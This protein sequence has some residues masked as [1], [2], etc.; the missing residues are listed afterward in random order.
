[1]YSFIVSPPIFKLIKVGRHVSHPPAG[2]RH[3][4]H[5]SRGQP[6]LEANH[7]RQDFTE[8]AE[9]FLMMDTVPDFTL[10]G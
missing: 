5:G 3:R 2:R 10:E 9:T 6:E 8:E 1:M 4:P 7:A